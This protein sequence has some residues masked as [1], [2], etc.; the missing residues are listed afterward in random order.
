[1]FVIVVKET[2]I[3]FSW[4]IPQIFRVTQKVWVIKDLYH[5]YTY[6]CEVRSCDTN[7]TSLV[8]PHHVTVYAPLIGCALEQRSIACDLLC[9]GCAVI[10]LSSINGESHLLFDCTYHVLSMSQPSN[11]GRIDGLQ[12][13]KGLPPYTMNCCQLDMQECQEQL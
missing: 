10:G 3:G 11:S 4:Y 8:H 1:M 9:R 12:L 13:D 6:G 5:L 7:R 2:I